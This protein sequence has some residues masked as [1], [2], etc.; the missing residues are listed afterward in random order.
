M[1]TQS[2]LRSGTTTKKQGRSHS[3]TMATIGEKPP[4]VYK[5]KDF[6][7]LGTIG[8]YELQTRDLNCR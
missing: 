5:S 4:G 3:V 7:D 2:R 1:S 8:V 6:G